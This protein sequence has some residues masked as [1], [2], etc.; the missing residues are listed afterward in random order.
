MQFWLAVFVK[1]IF[2]EGASAEKIKLHA[3]SGLQYR[4]KEINFP[5]FRKFWSIS[6]KRVPW[7]IIEKLFIC[8]I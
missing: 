7:K 2:F 3:F 5:E 1:V 4:F 8:E 6:R